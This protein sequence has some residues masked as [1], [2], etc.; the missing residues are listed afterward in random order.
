[1]NTPVSHSKPYLEAADHAAVRR[2]LESGMIAAGAEVRAFE[3]EAAAFAGAAAAVATAGGTAAL[4]MTL[5]AVGAGPS[6]EVVVPTYACPEVARAVRLAGAEPVPC[7]AGP[8][9]VLTPDSVRPALTPRTAAVVAVNVFG[10]RADLEGLAELGPAVVEDACQ[11]LGHLPQPGPAAVRVLS[12]QGTKEITCGEG[13]MALTADPALGRALAALR[14]EAHGPGA[15]PGRMSDIQAALGRGQLAR[16]PAFLARRRVLAARY[17]EV[18][19]PLAVEHPQALAESSV[20][21]RFPVLIEEGVPEMMDFFAARG[22]AVRRGVD[23]LIHRVLG[24]DSWNF[25]MAESLFA[26]TLSLPLYPAL[27]DA[28]QDR[29]IAACRAA[30]GGHGH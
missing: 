8:L 12:F 10:I 23:A 14:D 26:R 21:F 9:W 19:A 27:T 2:V 5:A 20:Q 28:E 3:A 15:T 22:V 25:P 24:L 13:G 1:M 4:A 17:R 11:S 6:T 7:D 18:L 30:W 29:V 16:Y